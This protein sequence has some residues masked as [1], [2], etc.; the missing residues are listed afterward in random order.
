[1]IVPKEVASK[2]IQ[3]VQSYSHRGVDK[4]L[5]LLHTRHNLHA[6][7]LT[8]L[9][10]LVEHVIHPC[11]IC[12]TCKPRSGGHPE[13]ATTI[14]SRNIRLPQSQSTL[15]ISVR[16]RCAKVTLWTVA[17]SLLTGQLAMF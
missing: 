4:T 5:E 15:S 2:V 12:Q 7:T 17:S 16:A 11:D 8:K 1:M 10:E 9:R 6:Y 13:R 3:E 14:P